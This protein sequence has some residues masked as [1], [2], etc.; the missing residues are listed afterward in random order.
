MRAVPLPAIVETLGVE[1]EAD[2]PG[3][4]RAHVSGAWN[5]PVFPN[6]GLTSAIALRAMEAELA[7]PHQSLRTFTTIF[8]STVEPG[9]LEIGVERLRLG[10][11]MSQLRADLRSRGRGTPGHVVTAAFGE[12]RDGFAFSYAAAPDVDS[13][14][15]YPGLAEVPGAGVPDFRPPFF[16]NVEV[17]RVHVFASFEKG[18]QGGR[19][20]SIRWIRYRV[21]PRARDGRIEPLA[22][23]PVADTMP[24]AIGQYLGP[25][26]PFYHAPSVDLTMRFF[27]DTEQEWF[28]TRSVCHWAGDGYASLETT[29][30]D[31]D[32]R[33]LAHGGQMVLLRYPDPRELGA[34]PREASA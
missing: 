19:A 6:G 34:R 2:L 27:A 29:L 9:P 16:D 26:F 15:A 33:L 12:T 23:V 28:L 30:W 3:R 4:Y 31:L 5:A 20:E 14:D 11:R 8:V 13:P 32:R 17:R 7:R 18:W 22:L 1:P 10:S 21:P 24:P 25:G